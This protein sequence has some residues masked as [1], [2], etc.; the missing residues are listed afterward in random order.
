MRV[1]LVS[2]L[3]YSLRQMDWVLRTASEFDLV[4]VAGDHLD[5]ASLVDP[6]VQIA[7]AREFLRGLSDRTRV[8]ASSGNHDL[9]ARDAN[10]EKVAA[11][12]QGLGD[13]VIV[14]GATTEIGG[15]LVTVCPW[16]DGPAGRD[17]VG[18][19]L[20]AASGAR[21][22]RRWIWVY[23][24]PPDSSP[25]SWTGRRH[26][27][28]MELVEWIDRYAPDVVLCGHVHEA[29]FM[30]DGGWHDR[31]GG[32]L[33]LNAGRQPGAVPCAVEVDLDASEAVWRSMEGIETIRLDRDPADA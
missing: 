11:W 3:H 19:Q 28:D 10:D 12:L 7:A 25:T 16:W 31:I 13:Q 9:E 33:V 18:A 5:I 29:P 20:E 2:D 32:T 14:D 4:V 21:G 1:L 27:G 8:I 6:D 17:T 24:A 23:H 30:A 22:D 15:V 26:Y